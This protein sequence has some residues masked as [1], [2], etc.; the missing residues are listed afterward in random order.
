MVDGIHIDRRGEVVT[1]LAARVVKD[2]K[3][4]PVLLPEPG[5]VSR[6]FA[7]LGRH[8]GKGTLRLTLSRV[9]QRR[10]DA[11]N[12]LLWGVI[13]AQVL[14]ALR[15]LALEVGESCPF[16]D[17]EDLHEALKHRHRASWILVHGPIPADV[18]VRHRC[19]NPACVRPDHLLTGSQA[20]NLDDMRERGRAVV[21]TPRL[22][23]QHHNAKL[24]PA[25]RAEGLSLA[26][27]GAEFGLHPATVHDV[28]LRR[29]WREVA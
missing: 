8:A 27:I 29:T 9:S 15:E 17:A 4:R 5:T 7:V 10:S 6:W 26:K 24:D 20:Q 14:D 28:V 1:E 22:G 12:R 21:P 11:Q 16:R 25:R 13:Y 3:G 2:V 18:V 23:T 19:D